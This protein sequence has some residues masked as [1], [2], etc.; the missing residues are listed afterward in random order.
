MIESGARRSR[1]RAQRIRLRELLRREG[2]RTVGAIV[3]LVLALV[4]LGVLV[5]FRARIFLGAEG[6][7]IALVLALAVRAQASRQKRGA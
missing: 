2:H 1:A 7:A 4:L 6:V 5:G 3:A